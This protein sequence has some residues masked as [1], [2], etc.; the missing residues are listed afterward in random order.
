V[1]D[2]TIDAQYDHQSVEFLYKTYEG[3]VETRTIMGL[4][5]A[6]AVNSWLKLE[7]ELYS[8]DWL[9]RLDKSG[10]GRTSD[11]KMDAVIKLVIGL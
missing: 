11:Q 3:E 1:T 10:V 6:A 5:A 2:E 7:L 9:Q 4:K 8:D